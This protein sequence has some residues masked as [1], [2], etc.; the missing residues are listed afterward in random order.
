LFE[1]IRRQYLLSS[2]DETGNHASSHFFFV[3]ITDCCNIECPICYAS[4]G[5][6]GRYF[7]DLDTVR[8]LGERIRAEGGK[9]VSLTGGDPCTHPD[10]K[11]IIR[12]LKHDLGLSP[13]IVTNG[14]RIA[15]DPEWLKPL[16][17]A[18][19]R[20]VQLQFDTFD[21]KTYKRMRG[22]SDVSEKMRAVDA[23]CSSGLRLGLVTTVCKHNI[24]ELNTIIDLAVTLTPA[25]NT[26]IL[27]CML[28]VGRFPSRDLVI[29][30]EAAIRQVSTGGEHYTADAY[31]FLPFPKFAPLGFEGHPDCEVSTFM[32]VDGRAAKPV[33]RQINIED[34]FRRMGTYTKRQTK[35]RADVAVVRCLFS[36]SNSFASFLDIMSRLRSLKTGTGSRNLFLITIGSF[37]HPD[38]RDETRLNSCVSCNVTTDGFES[39]CGRDITWAKHNAQHVQ[40]ES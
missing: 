12:L 28:P 6:A 19:L 20:K 3:E 36:S 33:T 31:D 14:I 35:T 5:P 10:L 1:S 38:C 13:L 32:R 9:W 30:R 26:L 39:M 25:L 21:N 4:A 24:R 40:E 18:G 15:K 23:I 22:R 2:E 29:D 7:M 16:I 27:Q 34:L 8:A 11:E 37:M 17:D